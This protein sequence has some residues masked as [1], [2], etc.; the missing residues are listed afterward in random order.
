MLERLLC[1]VGLVKIEMI[2]TCWVNLVNQSVIKR[3]FQFHLYSSLLATQPVHQQRH[4]VLGGVSDFD[5]G[6][7]N[8]K[9]PPSSEK[10]LDIRQ[11]QQQVAGKLWN[12]LYLTPTLYTFNSIAPN[13]N[14]IVL[15][16]TSCL[17][18][19]HEVGREVCIRSHVPFYRVAQRIYSALVSHFWP[20]AS[21]DSRNPP[22][23][24]T[25]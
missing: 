4:W 7:K 6:G 1:S 15:I 14:C 19:V 2:V 20:E 13:S 25:T 23:I 8:Q 12:Q 22:V 18:C 17:L 24:L 5:G 10:L 11:Q 3:L 16:L 21:W 9:S